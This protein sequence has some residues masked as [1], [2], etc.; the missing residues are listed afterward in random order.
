[1]IDRFS[2]PLY[3]GPFTVN[4]LSPQAA[5]LAAWYPGNLPGGNTLYDFT[6]GGRHIALTNGPVWKADNIGLP[7]VAFDGSNDYGSVASFPYYSE[8]S[9]FL[10]LKC[11]TVGQLASQ[12]SIASHHTTDGVGSDWFFFVNFSDQLRVDIPWILGGAVTGV[13]AI[14]DKTGWHHVGFTRSG[15]TGAWTYK[16]YLNGREDASATTGSNPATTAQTLVLANL[17]TAS[18]SATGHEMRDI[19]IYNRPLTPGEVSQIYNPETRYQLW[20]GYDI[21]SRAGSAAAGGGGANN[22]III[23]G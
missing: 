21:R 6:G 10:W 19:R 9:C 18:A 14:P 7:A 13:T 15:S 12:Y 16:V 4:H 3:R 17:S 22:Q 8:V 1:M 23:I 5:G 11:A 2:Y 20:A